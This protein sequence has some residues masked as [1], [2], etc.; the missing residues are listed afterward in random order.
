MYVSRC[1]LSNDNCRFSSKLNL[2]Y[3]AAQTAG[4]VLKNAPYESL[5]LSHNCLSGA[6][7]NEKNIHLI[8]S[9]QF[10]SI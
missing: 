5:K 2:K 6:L 3:F 9:Q 1:P 8:Y 10:L 4:N 7:L